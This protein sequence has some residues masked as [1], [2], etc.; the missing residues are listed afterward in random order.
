MKHP[1]VVCQE[2]S[3]VIKLCLG[4]Q[5]PL[6]A[7]DLLHDTCSPVEIKMSLSPFH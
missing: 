5:V 1:R 6:L 3:V 2:G 4:E 7:S